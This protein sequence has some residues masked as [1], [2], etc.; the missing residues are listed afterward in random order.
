MNSNYINNFEYKKHL[1][2]L[3]FLAI[4]LVYLFHINKDVFPLGFVGVDIFLL[5]QDM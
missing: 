3:R 2:L 4:S 1:D 5:S